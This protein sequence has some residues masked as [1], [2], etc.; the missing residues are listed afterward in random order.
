MEEK[1]TAFLEVKDLVVEYSS[2]DDV[3]HAVNGV[4]F[5]LERGK[6][7]ALVGETGAGKTTIAKTIM[8]IL[9]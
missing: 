8:R 7:L 2:G 5:S 3:V 9:P 6:T 4:S 1:T